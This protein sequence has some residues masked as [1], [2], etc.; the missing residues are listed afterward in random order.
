MSANSKAKIICLKVNVLSV[1]YNTHNSLTSIKKRDK[2]ERK[3]AERRQSL[4]TSRVKEAFE[5]K[6]LKNK[7]FFI[8]H[9]NVFSENKFH[10]PDNR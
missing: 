4:V 7:T 5:N 3:E 10:I 8:V 1:G 9:A 2:D 6:T